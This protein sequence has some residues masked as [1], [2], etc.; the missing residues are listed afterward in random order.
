MQLT[1]KAIQAIVPFVPFI[2]SFI[3]EGKLFDTAQEFS[4][5]YSGGS[6]EATTMGEHTFAIPPDGEYNVVNPDNYF[7]GVMDHYTY[8]AAITLMVYN[9]LLWLCAEKYPD[10]FN[11]SLSDAFYAMKDAACNDER[12]N[13]GLLH[14]FLD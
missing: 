10:R 2:T 14:S 1:H 8:G 4:E 3:V 13:A 12:V 5:D 7:S 6:W 11:D 9:R